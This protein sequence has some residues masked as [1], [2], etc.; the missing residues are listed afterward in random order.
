MTKTNTSNKKIAQKII[1][2][3]FTRYPEWKQEPLILPKPVYSS[4]LANVDISKK[5]MAQVP[6][7]EIT[8]S[9][10]C[11]TIISDTAFRIDD[12][13]ANARFQVRHS[14]RQQTWFVW[15]YLV[16]LKEFTNQTGVIYTPPD[17]YQVNNSSVE[18]PSL[19]REGEVI[20]GKL[21]IA[22]KAHPKLTE[23]H[24]VICVKNRK[25]I[26]RSWLNHMNNY[27][28]MTLWLDD[29]S[30][31]NGRQGV[32][33]FNSTPEQE[34]VIFRDYLL[35]VWNIKT[36]LRT[37]SDKPFMEN[38]KPNLEIVIEDEDSLQNLLRLVAPVIPVREMLYKVCFVPK[39]QNLLQRWKTELVGLVKPDF[40]QYVDDFYATK[41]DNTYC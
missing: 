22:S 25:T 35:T 12:G 27:F 11:G 9:V 5:Q 1:D 40:R 34:Q 26:Q 16:I 24:R 37:K 8:K 29:G 2:D 14:T 41:I 39:D 4:K 13:Y 20:L 31:S 10:L 15:K 23:L 33:C 28:L 21:K 7:D 32:I 38:G 36:R 19:L 30:L 18:R 17:G 6:L 3:A